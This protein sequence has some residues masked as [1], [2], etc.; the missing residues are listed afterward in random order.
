MSMCEHVTGTCMYAKTRSFLEF[1]FSFNIRPRGLTLSS[2]DIRA[3][4]IAP[5]LFMGRT[6]TRGRPTVRCQ[7]LEHSSCLRGLLGTNDKSMRTV[8]GSET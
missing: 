5:G 8:S 7:V 3:T 4:A 2:P 6:V 1:H